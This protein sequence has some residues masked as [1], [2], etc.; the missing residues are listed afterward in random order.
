M[1]TALAIIAAISASVAIILLFRAASAV[2]RAEAAADSAVVFAER[3][4]LLADDANSLALRASAF[5]SSAA[6]IALRRSSEAS[7]ASR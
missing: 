5:A 4:N 7:S 3:A 6:A 2:R 1:L